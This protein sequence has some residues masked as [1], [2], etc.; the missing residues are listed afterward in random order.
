MDSSI[1]LPASDV[2][3]FADVLYNKPLGRGVARRVHEA[4]QRGSW[5][6]VGSMKGREGRTAFLEQLLALGVS[7]AFPVSDRD[8][9]VVELSAVGWKAKSV[10][11]L[12]INRP[13]S[14]P[15]A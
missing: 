15:A 7:E 11:I 10:E 4:K 13:S 6:I 14:S 2:C 9:T 12:E 8:D 5:V 1:P 3:I